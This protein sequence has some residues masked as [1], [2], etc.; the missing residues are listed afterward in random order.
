[1][2]IRGVGWIRSDEKGLSDIRNIPL[3][4]VDGTVVRVADVAT[5]AFGAEI[6]QGAVNMTHRDANGKPE[7]LGEVVVGVVSVH[8]IAIAFTRQ[9]C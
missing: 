5:V 7:A 6:R 4:T 9:L 1:M 2:V 3:K 8:G